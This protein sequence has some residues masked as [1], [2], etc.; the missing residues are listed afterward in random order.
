MFSEIVKLVP[1]IDRAAMEKMFRTLSQ[2]FSTVAKKFGQ[3]M[4]NALK[5]GPMIALGGALVA[6]LLNPLQKAE[7]IID[8]MT[9]KGDDAVTNAEELGTTPGKILRLEGLGQA[10]GLDPEKMRTMLGKFQSALAAEQEAAKNP[11][12]PEGTLRRFVGET[13]MADAFFKFIQSLQNV[14]PSRR[15][16][17]QDE[18]FGEKLRGKGSEFFNAKPEDLEAVLKKFR[19]VEDL[20]EAAKK[21]GKLSDLKDLLGAVR[22]VD[23]VVVKAGLM[24]QGQIQQLDVAKKRE[25][26]GENESLKQFDSLKSTSIAVQE[27]TEKFDH[28]ATEAMKD[29]APQLIKSIEGLKMIFEAVQPLLIEA[30]DLLSVGFDKTINAIATASTWAQTAWAEFKGSSFYKFF[31]RK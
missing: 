4:K 21:L 18:I 6:K 13:D 3:G 8:R 5:L 22:E 31:G 9:G 30:K 16:V 20:D 2:R 10:F 26:R 14:E 11:A 25:L 15:V 7:D 23:D 28:F 29:L 12:N 19:S 24:N 1:S 17:V 27:L